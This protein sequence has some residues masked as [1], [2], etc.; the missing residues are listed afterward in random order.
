MTDTDQCDRDKRIGHPDCEPNA[1]VLFSRLGKKAI[2]ASGHYCSHRDCCRGAGVGPASKRASG[3]FVVRRRGCRMDRATALGL[4]LMFLCLGGCSRQA[5]DCGAEDSIA[6]VIPIIQERIQERTRERIRS[7]NVSRPASLS[8]VRAT[9]SQA[10]IVIIDVRTTQSDPNST[11]R[12]CV[13]R[14]RVTIP[15]PMLQE[16]ERA[17]QAAGASSISDLADSSD[18][19]RN[20]DSFTADIEYNVQPTDAGDR[21]YAEI[22]NSDGYVNYFSEV[23]AYYL[24]RPGIEQARQERDRATAEQQRIEQAQQQ[25][26]ETAMAEQRGAAL[27]QARSEYRLAEQGINTVWQSIPPDTRRQLLDLQRA[28][29]RGRQASCTIEAAQTSTQPQERE[30]ARLRCDTRLTSERMNY[31]RQ[32]A[33]Y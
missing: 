28:W 13:A 17:R 11:R 4:F 3:V 21:I 10:N 30:A 29:I 24:M 31:L 33:R 8:R 23:L 9:V 19:D 6:A 26:Q 1:G 5:A 12:F 22:D 18:I 20:A 15:A 25:E 32:Y 7:S 14:M 16:T 2:G 27:D